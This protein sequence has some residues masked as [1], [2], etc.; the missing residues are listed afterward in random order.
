MTR[1]SM[2]TC[3]RPTWSGITTSPRASSMRA[4]RRF[5]PS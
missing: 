4:G 3:R 1:S 2:R 5:S